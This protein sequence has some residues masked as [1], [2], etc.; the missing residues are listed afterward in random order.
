MMKQ[1]L[2]LNHYQNLKATN[3]KQRQ[4]L[5]PNIFWIDSN[6]ANKQNKQIENKSHDK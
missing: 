5:K 4:N 1:E 6:H 3:K 2:N